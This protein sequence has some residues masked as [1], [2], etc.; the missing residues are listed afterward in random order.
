MRSTLGLCALVLL[1]WVQA[2]P[3]QIV[4]CVRVIGPFFPNYIQVDPLA[5][6]SSQTITI[7]FGRLN[8]APVSL[9]ANV[10]GSIIDVTLGVGFLGFATPP[11]PT[12]RR[13]TLGP[14]AAG[15]YTINFYTRS[16]GL[17]NPPNFQGTMPLAVTGSAADIPTMSEVA[18]ALL[19]LLIAVAAWR[20]FRVAR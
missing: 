16:F 18:L 7:E 1:S 3:A 4:D 20:I 19:A 12:C 5:P 15:N 14:L 11:D 9:D 2:V 10:S 17:Q 13:I 6:T 8:N